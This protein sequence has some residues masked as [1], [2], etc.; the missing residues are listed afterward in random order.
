MNH[1]CK[2]RFDPGRLVATP[3]ALDAIPRAEWIFALH[4]HLQGDW[5]DVSA[6]DKKRNDCALLNSDRMVSQYRTSSNRSFWIITEADR[7]A[8]VILLPEE[9]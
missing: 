5:G 6:V 3:G 2:G 4:R 8:T 1:I 9:Y 7:S